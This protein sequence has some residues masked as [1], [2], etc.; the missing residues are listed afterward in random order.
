MRKY[1]IINGYWKDDKTEFTDYVVTNYD[2]DDGDEN[3]FYYGLNESDLANSS[4]D[5]ALEFVVT[6][7]DEIAF[8]FN[9]GDKVKHDIYGDGVVVEVVSMKEIYVRFGDQPDEDVV[10]YD[11]SELTLV[12]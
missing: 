12:I 3:V 1:W 5:D 8:E 10:D 2:D 7:Y 9:V 6:S 11:N 4:E